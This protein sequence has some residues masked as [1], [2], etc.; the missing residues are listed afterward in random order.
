[1]L[2]IAAVIL[3]NLL[4]FKFRFLLSAKFLGNT[5]QRLSSNHAV[6]FFVKL[7]KSDAG[8]LYVCQGVFGQDGKKNAS[9]LAAKAI[10]ALC[11]VLPFTT[12]SILVR[13]ISA[14]YSVILHPNFKITCRKRKL[15]FR[16]HFIPFLWYTIDR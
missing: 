7:S 9:D 5:A 13:F 10:A 11:A 6:S 12:I 3:I 1:M 16:L 2:A 15:D 14:F 8:I 4:I